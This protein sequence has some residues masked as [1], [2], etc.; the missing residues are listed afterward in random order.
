[1]SFE[2]AEV[3]TAE[4][5][6]APAFRL[7][8]GLSEIPGCPVSLKKLGDIYGARPKDVLSTEIL[9]NKRGAAGTG[10]AAVLLRSARSLLKLA[11]T[12]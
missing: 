3:S 8:S 6:L 10:S 11:N 9:T 5:G 4:L 1:M 12:N 7:L 2:E